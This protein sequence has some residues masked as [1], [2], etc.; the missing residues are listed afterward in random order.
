MT[1]EK[2]EIVFGPAPKGVL[3]IGTD[4]TN[5]DIVPA[6]DDLPDGIPAVKYISTVRQTQQGK[7]RRP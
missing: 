3:T 7:S 5:P 6:S 1:V 4:E 2:L